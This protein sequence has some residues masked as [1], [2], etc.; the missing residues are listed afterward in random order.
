MT[1]AFLYAGQGSQH[2]GMGKDL[3]DTAPLFAQVYDNAPLD[4]DLKSLCFDG[5]EDK[6]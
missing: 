6:L 5:P 3:Y 4:F 2:L 1:M